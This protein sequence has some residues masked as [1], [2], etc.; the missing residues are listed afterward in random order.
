[1][2]PT[3]RIVNGNPILL[4]KILSKRFSLE[5]VSATVIASANAFASKE[6]QKTVNDRGFACSKQ[7]LWRGR[8]AAKGKKKKEELEGG[9]KRTNACRDLPVVSIK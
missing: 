5:M 4:A 3:N 9:W 2:F 1:M 6:A 8:R 7:V